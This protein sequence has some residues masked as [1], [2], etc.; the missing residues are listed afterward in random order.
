MYIEYIEYIE[1][2]AAA[3]SFLIRAALPWRRGYGNR[4]V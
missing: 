2:A 1:Q 4:D 3:G